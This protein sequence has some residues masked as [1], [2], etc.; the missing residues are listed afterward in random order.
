[1]DNNFCS[2]SS[3]HFSIQSNTNM[4]TPCHDPILKLLNPL[5]WK[6]ITST[7]YKPRLTYLTNPISL[8]HISYAA[9]LKYSLTKLYYLNQISSKKITQSNL[10]PF[11]SIDIHNTN[12]PLNNYHERT[13]QT[14]KPFRLSYTT[15]EE[16]HS[17]DF[18]ILIRFSGR[19]CFVSCQTNQRKW[20]NILVIFIFFMFDDWRS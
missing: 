16:H 17:F 11:P 14:W 12:K 3:A 7:C 2:L 18:N 19:W 13:T 10:L 20:S 8:S 15:D 4:Q 9:H 6:L 5:H 1:M